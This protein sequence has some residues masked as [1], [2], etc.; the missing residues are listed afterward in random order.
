MQGI[1]TVTAVSPFD[2][3]TDADVLHKAM[4]GFGTDEKALISI[5]CHRTSSQRT[6][7]NQ[8]YKSSYGKV[9]TT[10]HNSIII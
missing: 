1:P 5:L 7:I 10:R 8:A 2:A 4:K 9:F 6:A 3:R